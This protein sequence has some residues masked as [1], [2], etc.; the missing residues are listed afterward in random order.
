MKDGIKWDLLSADQLGH[1]E[2]DR[3][4]VVGRSLVVPSSRPL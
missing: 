4:E 1:N 3:N 2:N